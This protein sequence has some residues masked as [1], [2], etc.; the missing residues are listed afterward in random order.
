[1]KKTASQKGK[2]KILL[3]VFLVLVLVII[4]LLA[5][6]SAI[7]DSSVNSNWVTML[8]GFWSAGATCA[9]GGVALW[10]NRNYKKQAEENNRRLEELTIMPECCL[11]SIDYRDTH[12][13][14]SDLYMRPKDGSM[15][16]YDIEFTNLSLPILQFAID[17]VTIINKQTNCIEE[18]VTEFKHTKKDISILGQFESYTI[19]IGINN[20][21]FNKDITI[22]M[23]FTFKNVYQ[24]R[25]YKEINFDVMNK[26]YY[27]AQAQNLSSQKATRKK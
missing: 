10:Q 14:G 9:L 16:N 7:Y 17:K 20:N 21:H 5:I 19:T 6:I 27:N 23:L 2:L 1:M 25:Y 4:V 24:D 26:T 3:I 8:A 22:K 18:E 12:F 11:K 15:K 13:M